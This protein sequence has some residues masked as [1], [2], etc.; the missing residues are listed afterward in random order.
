MRKLVVTTFLTL[1]GV[2]QAPGGPG[3]DDDGFAFGG[4]SV[5]FWD[6]L[7]GQVMDEFMNRPFDLV[8]GRRTYDI[9]AAY[10]PNARAAGAWQ[11]EPDPDTHAS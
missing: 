10:W 6:E 5:G 11:R 9:F 2:M 3:E 7:M 4:W 8:L 1:D